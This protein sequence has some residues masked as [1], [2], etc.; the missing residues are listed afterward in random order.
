MNGLL[1]LPVTAVVNS[2]FGPAVNKIREA[3]NLAARR[4]EAAY[5]G[6]LSMEEAGYLT[7]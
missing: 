5:H 1:I 6:G 2:Y 4:R 7:V 3:G